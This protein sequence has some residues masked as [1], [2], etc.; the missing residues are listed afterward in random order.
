M[1]S[2]MKTRLRDRRE[3]GHFWADNEIIDVFGDALG[4]NGISVYMTM[5][6]FCF[7]TE[8]KLSLRDIAAAARMG[9][10]TVARSM[11][12]LVTLGLVI[13][14]K[15]LRSKTVST[16]ALASVKA[17]TQEY[18]RQ[19]VSPRDRL[20]ER[21]TEEAVS[22]A[23]KSTLAEMVALPSENCL[24]VRQ[25]VSLADS[26]D[27]KICAAQDETDLSQNDP[28]FETDLSHQTVPFNYKTQDTRLQDTTPLPPK[29]ERVSL[30]ATNRGADQP[31]ADAMTR[32][33]KGRLV[34]ED[35]VTKVMRE[36]NFA[37]ER[38]RS[39]IAAGMRSYHAKTDEPADCNRTAELMVESYGR[40]AEYASLL[41]FIV[42]PRKFI[43]HGLWLD[44]R[45]WPW[46]Q[47]K[48]NAAKRF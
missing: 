31:A 30:S 25:M 47:E 14:T 15:G 40:Y 46:D 7:G 34:C 11:K 32:N 36:C 22:A 13:E 5:T 12:V 1:G 10:D 44:E 33:A 17:L 37:D 16:W 28:D 27:K 29:G 38:L 41:R 9:K 8:V 21:K 45:L 35:A 20:E 2:E 3:P 39:V 24:P 23:R 48:V 19:S 42:G 26:V 4:Q 43:L 18:I 6:R